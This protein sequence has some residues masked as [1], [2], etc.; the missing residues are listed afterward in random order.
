[1]VITNERVEML[2]NALMKDVDFANEIIE[3]EAE[4]AVEALKAK[5]FDFTADELAA[6]AEDLA[7][8]L[9]ENDQL[10]EDDLDDVSGGCYIHHHRR[11]PFRR[12][13]H[14][15]YGPYC[16]TISYRKCRW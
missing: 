16:V 8:Y 11:P 6:F 5:G 14:Y 9:T 12:Y 15:H 13:T 1:M 4:E 2:A 10:S 3:M 7:A